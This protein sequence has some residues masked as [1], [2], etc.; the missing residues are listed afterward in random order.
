MEDTTDVEMQEP[1]AAV[2]LSERRMMEVEVAEN[3]AKRVMAEREKEAK[4]RIVSSA[5]AGTGHLGRR[6]A[7]SERPHQLLRKTYDGEDA[8]STT[9]VSMST[10]VMDLSETDRIKYYEVAWRVLGSETVHPR[11][12]CGGTAADILGLLKY[13]HGQF[14]LK[15]EDIDMRVLTPQ[16]AYERACAIYD[17]SPTDI[18]TP[19]HI[20]DLYM[21]GMT[22]ITKLFVTLSTEV[23]EL[24]L[25]DRG[26]PNVAHLAGMAVSQRYRDDG[27]GDGKGREYEHEHGGEDE[28]DNENEERKV[29]PEEMRDRAIVSMSTI[30]MEA[31]KYAYDILQVLHVARDMILTMTNGAATLSPGCRNSRGGTVSQITALAF[32]NMAE[33]KATVRI[34]LHVYHTLHTMQAKRSSE[35]VM[36]P[37]KLQVCV[38][39]SKTK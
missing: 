27:D 34:K 18:L 31:R 24:A 15:M 1:V 10:R 26:N 30:A 6:E 39:A 7:A 33:L 5:G 25:N 20:D 17:V 29:D 12:L 11:M 14:V 36:L 28:D 38:R 32:T 23:T 8:L 4:K 2:G 37:H 9:T 13:I 3:E 35:N 22:R 16:Q 21:D 19:R